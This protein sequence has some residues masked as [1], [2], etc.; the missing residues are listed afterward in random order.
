MHI[1]YRKYTRMDAAADDD[2]DA[3]MLKV[4][5]GKGNTYDDNA[6]MMMLMMTMVMMTL[7]INAQ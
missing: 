4:D 5:D 3:K 7:F 2:G 6:I 1:P